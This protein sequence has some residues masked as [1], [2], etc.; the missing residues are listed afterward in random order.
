MAAQSEAVA[1]GC[2]EWRGVVN[3]SGYGQ[4]KYE[5][6]HQGAYR[7]AY[8]LNVGPIAPGLEIDHLCRNRLCVNPLHLEAVTRA[9]NNRRSNNPFGINARKTHCHRGHE[10]T[11]AN[12]HRHPDG[13]RECRTCRQIRNSRRTKAAAA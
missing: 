3:K 10:F 6:K 4:I 7:V 9:E 1:S 2:I 8:L 11:E 13:R 5:G 12:T